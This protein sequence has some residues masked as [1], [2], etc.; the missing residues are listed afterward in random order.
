M[1]YNILEVEKESKSVDNLITVDDVSVTYVKSQ[2]CTER[3]DCVQTMV[4]SS[5]NNGIARFINIKTGKNGWSICEV[6]EL[7]EILADF[8][9]RSGIEL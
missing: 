2:D 8:C 5:R 1:Q 6:D 7:K 3:E 4:V 9:K